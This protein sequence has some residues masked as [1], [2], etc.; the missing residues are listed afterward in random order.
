M[1]G[2][3]VQDTEGGSWPFVEVT[4]LWPHWS[5]CR[6]S[7]SMGKFQDATINLP[8]AD[9]QLLEAPWAAGQEDHQPLGLGQKNGQLLLIYV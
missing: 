1:Q 8:A 4:G 5:T 6:W 3:Q 2:D 9:L 7:R